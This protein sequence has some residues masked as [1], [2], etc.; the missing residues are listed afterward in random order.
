MRIAGVGQEGA[1]DRQQLPLTRRDVGGLL[2]QQAVV[3]A[4]QRRLPVVAMAI[5]S[6]IIVGCHLAIRTEAKVISA[7]AG[8]MTA[9]SRRSP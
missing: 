6:G 9:R 8:Q 2:V 1:R 7:D 3:A 4:G 5:A